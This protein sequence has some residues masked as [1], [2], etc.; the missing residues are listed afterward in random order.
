[1]FDEFAS[2]LFLSPGDSAANYAV[3]I[4][5]SLPRDKQYEFIEAIANGFS[6]YWGHEKN[7]GL[8]RLKTLVSTFDDEHQ[9]KLVS[10]L[11]QREKSVWRGNSIRQ[12]WENAFD[13]LKNEHTITDP[14]IIKAILKLSLGSF[15]FE[16]RANEAVKKIEQNSQTESVVRDAVF[17]WMASELTNPKYNTFEKITGT[18]T[19]FNLGEPP[20]EVKNS[21]MP[22]M[23]QEIMSGK[24][25]HIKQLQNIF[26][27]DAV[28][29]VNADNLSANK[30]QPNEL[31]KFIKYF[32]DAELETL[33]PNTILKARELIL[34]KLSSDQDLA[35]YFLENL[36]K[37]YTQTWAEEGIKKSIQHYSVANKFVQ[38]VDNQ[39][40]NWVN[41]PWVAGILTEAKKIVEE[42][43][44]HWDDDEDE[45][46]DAESEGFL[47]EDPFKNHPLREIRSSL[48]VIF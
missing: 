46:Y 29:F 38:A 32:G 10:N 8:D 4:L 19:K 35:D 34:T 48:G 3:E 47:E 21:V 45:Y 37:Y 26:H 28:F 2:D 15:N 43:K 27:L 9:T 30:I 24:L 39:G 22:L 7:S 18:I 23:E 11:L 31:I 1:L 17:E 42:Q 41:E 40:A 36:P 5:Q 16:S 33:L 6:R 13:L 20:I 12:D 14:I 44:A 25:D